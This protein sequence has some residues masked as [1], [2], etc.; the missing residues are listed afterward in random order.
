MKIRKPLGRRAL[1]LGTVAGLVVAGSS[2]VAAAA[3]AAPAP[4]GGAAGAGSTTGARL[5]PHSLP[6]TGVESNRP[7]ALGNTPNG[8]TG[9]PGSTAP[10]GVPSKGNY[11]FLLKLSQSSTM[12]AYG[13]AASRGKAA[14]SSAAKAQYSRVKDAQ[15]QV[16]SAL[17]KGSRV[18]YRSHSVLAAVA[19]YTDVNNLSALRGISGVKAVYPIA[20]K[21]LANANAVPFQ[22]GAAAWT[23]HTNNLG[24]GS[25]IAVIDT[26]IDYT[27]ANFG[28]PGTV[29]AYNNAKAHDA[30]APDPSLFPST[31]VVGGTDLV[32][33][34]YDAG[35]T[36]PAVATPQPDA[37][38][39]DCGGHGSHVAGTAAGIGENADG[40]TY[41]GAYN[42]STPFSTMKIG[43]GMAPKA[44]LY[45]YKV[46][47][48]EGTTNVVAEAIDKASD[49]NGDGDPSDHVSVINMSL[50]SDYGSPQD[51]DSVAANAAASL[52]ITVA[53]A[54]G[55]GGDYYDVGGSPGDAVR[56][57]AVANSVDAQDILDTATVSPTVCGA[58]ACGA[59][60][61]VAYDWATKPDLSGALVK[62][63]Q[64]TN[65]DGCDPL[66]AADS[67][68]V[69]GKV[70]FLEWTDNDTAR[71]CG[72]VARSANVTTAGAVGFVFADDSESFAAGITGSDTIP[73]VLVTKSAG[74]AIRAAL[75]SG[76]SVSG[77]SAATFTQT[78]PQNN[79]KVNASSSRGIRGAGNVKPDV[80]A[81]GTGV[82]STGA[83]LGTGGVTESGTSMATPMVAG[84]AALVHSAHTT[85]TAEEVKADIMNTAGQ[86]L[87]KSDNHTGSKYAPNRV[88]A[89]RI[90]ADAALDNTVLAYVQN[91]PGAV[92]V[93]FGP[94]AVSAPTTITKTVKVVNKGSASASYSVGYQTLTNVVPGVTMYKVSPSTLTVA[95]GATKTFTVS[96]V[97]TNPKA[98]SKTID[99][100]MDTSQA[101][102]PREFLADASGR[103]LF[104]PTAGATVQ[105]RVPVYSAPRPAST[106]SQPASLTL[107]AGSTQK[108]NLPLTGTGVGQGSGTARIDSINAGFELQGMSTQAPT[109]SATVLNN[110]VHFSDERTA[111]LHYVGVTSDAPQARSVGLDPLS[112][113]FAYVAVSTYGRWRT[114]ASTQE[115]DVYID[116]NGD[117]N[118]DAVV[119][120]TRY[121]GQ[122]VFV[123]ELIDL[124]T[125]TA[126]DVEPI[127]GRFG[128]LDTA[129]FDSDTMVMPV[130]LGGLPG[131][132]NGQSRIRYS[133]ASFSNESAGPIDTIGFNDQGQ[134]Q[135]PLSFDVLRPGLA[136]YGAY[137]ADTSFVLVSDQ[138]GGSVVVRR[139]TSTYYA[140]KPVGVLM[141][142]FHNAS[143]AKAQKVFLK[144]ASKVTLK[145]SASTVKLHG[146]VT[147]TVTVTNS[148]GV[149]PTGKISIRRV[150]G[151]I[152]SS[153]NLVN[154]KVSLPVSPGAR[155]KYTVRAEYTGD[156][157]YVAANSAATTLTVS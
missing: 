72:S 127:N 105:L 22:G 26:G 88:G 119:F 50:G 43:P 84:L 54:S 21:T 75:A 15:A 49:P 10:T 41:A 13:S 42:N 137:T 104:T 76:V 63:S 48:C 16:V 131:V 68:A 144:S 153:G 135:N 120:N 2:A 40:S 97:I 57:I 102:L 19:V 11:G 80:T 64:S 1:V 136:V 156:S 98:L 142:H 141:V 37:N 56:P 100:T 111:D 8:A 55:N 150:G 112:D 70:A 14:A 30:E 99:P 83:G 91:D 3:P 122:D 115:F 33:D 74:D 90:K 39:L 121:S 18:L 6:L 93:S 81:V 149:V 45:A 23:A 12:S 5:R 52:G 114:P 7:R 146:K 118:P 103:V 124:T 20:P 129:L 152:F 148:G 87:S 62:L 86:D 34:A 53:V 4:P 69:N 125:N 123:S 32:G 36:D 85:W 139:D 35:S 107:P 66:N 134:M 96:L 113:G 17:P 61:S 143:G 154:G 140:D 157:N 89:G 92:S 67:A 51:G 73:G 116:T 9:E 145:L 65:T 77:T 108:A 110:C 128:N 38:P 47:G 60:R 133:V 94:V 95:A 109:C 27:H 44:T 151:G 46:F 138:P 31:K 71:R 78:L 126:V 101:G 58:N 28:G 29:A 106:M 82:F 24:A 59:E 155:G 117:N 132:S 147:A 130:W 79:D 25:S